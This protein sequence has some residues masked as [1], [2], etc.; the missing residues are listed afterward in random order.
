MVWSFDTAVRTL[1]Q[2]CRGEPI[3]GQQAV[4]HVLLNR[5][6]DGRWGKTLAE[7]CLSEFKGVHQFS[8]WNRNDPNRV[9]A[10]RL[11][12]SDPI[13]SHLSGVLQSVTAS[14]TDPTGGATHYVNLAIVTPP[15]TEGATLCGKF[16]SQTF[17]KDVK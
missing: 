17:Y 3:D 7:V 1:W 2:E 6:K 9:A 12:D 4:A 16:G 13:L 11:A 14:A 10:C 5:V 15:W 8:G